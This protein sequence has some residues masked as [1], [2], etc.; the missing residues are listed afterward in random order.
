MALNQW[1]YATPAQVNYIKRLLAEAQKYAPFRALGYAL[2]S[3]WENRLLKSEATKM[4]DDLLAAKARG[5]QAEVKPIDTLAGLQRLCTLFWMIGRGDSRDRIQD[6]ADRYAK[7][8][9]G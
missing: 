6:A 4:I 5:W 9:G 1:I 3:G 2:T 7:A 8:F